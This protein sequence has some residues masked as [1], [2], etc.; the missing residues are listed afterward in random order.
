MADA[1][2]LSQ[3]HAFAESEYASEPV[4][5]RRCVLI[6]QHRDHVGICTLRHGYLLNLAP[7]FSPA[8]QDSRAPGATSVLSG[9]DRSPPA[10]GLL[11]DL[12]S[13]PIPQSPA[14]IVGAAPLD[15]HLHPMVPAVVFHPAVHRPA[16]VAPGAGFRG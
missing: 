4:E 16:I 5:G 12:G 15:R 6:H 8:R 1:L 9:L 3:S 13:S 14:V 7:K 11:P 10:V 2:A